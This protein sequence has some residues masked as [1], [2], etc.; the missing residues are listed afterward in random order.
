MPEVTDVPKAAPIIESTRQMGEIYAGFLRPRPDLTP[1]DYSEVRARVGLFLGKLRESYPQASQST[2]DTISQLFAGPWLLNNETLQRGTSEVS[3]KELSARIQHHLVHAAFYA[4][5]PNASDTYRTSMFFLL[6]AIERSATSATGR[7]YN[8]LQFL[9]GVKSELAII[10]ALTANGYR[11][12]IPDYRESSDP[13]KKLTSETLEWD[14]WQAVDLIAVSPRG[15]MVLVD[16]KGKKQNGDGNHLSV[17]DDEDLKTDVTISKKPVESNLPPKLTTMIQKLR[18]DGLLNGIAPERTT[19]IIP[20]SSS[21]LG[22][23]GTTENSKSYREAI[24][25][26]ATLKPSHQSTI[27]QALN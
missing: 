16:A 26:F 23:L 15:K 13:K 1:A 20:T 24:D 11:V 9:N 2:I 8:V 21:E 5:E 17:D 10:K 18:S 25:R 27:I 4:S 3:Q 12:F 7:D 22:V 14:V 19:I 6:K